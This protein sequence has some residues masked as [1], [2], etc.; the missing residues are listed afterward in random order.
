MWYTKYAMPTLTLEQWKIDLEK[1]RFGQ[2]WVH[3]DPPGHLYE[4]H[5]HPID[6][7]YVALKGSM[8]VWLGEQE[9]TVGEGERL[10]IAKHISH[11]AKIGPHGCKF[12]IGCRI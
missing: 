4:E 9:H 5:S 7:V 12:L 10:D 11:R 8:I 1:E 2:L 3:E 6:T